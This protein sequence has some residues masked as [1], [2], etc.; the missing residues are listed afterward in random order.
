MVSM[1]EV[2]QGKVSLEDIATITHYLDMKNDI[3]YV[4]IHKNDKKNEGGR[5]YGRS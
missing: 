1:D 2:K 3:E 4:N 5:G